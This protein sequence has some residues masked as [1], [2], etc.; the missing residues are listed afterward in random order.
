MILFIHQ[1]DVTGSWHIKWFTDLV[2]AMKG[3]ILFA[4]VRT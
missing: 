3:G 4:E 2:N 1:Q